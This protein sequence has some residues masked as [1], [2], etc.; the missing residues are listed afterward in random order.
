MI[1]VSRFMF[2]ICVMDDRMNIIILF[3][4]MYRQF[5][6][7]YYLPLFNGQYQVWFEIS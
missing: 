1:L 5:V 7:L 6:L 2:L 4:N 3:G